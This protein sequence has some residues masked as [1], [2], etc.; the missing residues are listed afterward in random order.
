VMKHEPYLLY[1]RSL[2]FLNFCIL[3]CHSII[4][5]FKNTPKLYLKLQLRINIAKIVKKKIAHTLSSAIFL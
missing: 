1:E 3:F 4:V 2:V 5:C